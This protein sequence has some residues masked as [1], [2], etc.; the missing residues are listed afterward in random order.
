MR[1]VLDIYDL[2]EGRAQT[3][4]AVESHIEAPNW[5]PS[6]DHLIV[7][8]EGRLFRV[9][10]V[11]PELQPI[12]VTGVKWLNNDHGIS[13]DG[14]TLVVSDSPARGTSL[15]YT[16]PKAG[17]V[18]VQV[19]PLAPSWWHGWSP[20]GARLAYTCMRGGQFGIA[21]CA[22]D[23]GDEQV[24]VTSAHH[25]DGPDYTPDGA[26]IWF[27]SDRGGAMDLWRMHPNGTG[28]EQMTEDARVN[29]FPHPSPDGRH[30]VYLT[31]APGTD[32]HP[33]E[34]DVDLRLIDLTT[35]ETRVLTE[36]FGG[37]GTL[38]VPCWSPDGKRFAYMR[39]AQ[40]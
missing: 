19:T 32:G 2:A 24:L 11:A 8:G 35:G 13:P 27:N 26:W 40:G 10:L 29:W 9:P 20:D 21:T 33:A 14:E 37:Q 39:Y 5:A 18:P 16:L 25:Y 23:G 22:L 31:Y 1:S 38:N 36:V 34:R 6:G 4:L 28:L 3:L 30:V 7:N 17:G 15:I 12:E